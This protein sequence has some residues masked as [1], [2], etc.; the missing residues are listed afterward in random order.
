VFLNAAGATP[1][2]GQTALFQDLA[3]KPLSVAPEW[4]GTLGAS[5]DVPVGDSTKLGISADARYSDSYLASAFGNPDSKQ[6]SYVSIDA[7]IR[8]GD[9]DD[10]WQVALI[11]KNLTNRFYIT[12]IVDGPSTGTGTGTAAGVHA[13]QLGFATLPRTVQI[14]ISGKF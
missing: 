11:G 12:G 10:R 13:D 2:A 1:G 5:Y 4:T 8:F 9:V 7:S 14:Q 3:G 6:K